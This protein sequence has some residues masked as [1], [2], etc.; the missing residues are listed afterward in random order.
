MGLLS[1]LTELCRG[2]R[3][4]GWVSKGDLLVRLALRILNELL[5]E[6]RQGDFELLHLTEADERHSDADQ[7]EGEEDAG[8]DK[9]EDVIAD[10][11]LRKDKTGEG[12]DDEGEERQQ[13]PMIFAR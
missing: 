4:R 13:D 1:M 11:D 7:R 8:C 6:G 5:I 3:G 9:A 10:P 2:S 12:R